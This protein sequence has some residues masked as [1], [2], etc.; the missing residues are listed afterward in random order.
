[1]PPSASLTSTPWIFKSFRVGA[2]EGYLAEKNPLTK[3]FD[4]LNN[5][6]VLFIMVSVVVLDIVFDIILLYKTNFLKKVFLRKG[7]LK[8]RI[9]KRRIFKR[10]MFKNKFSKR[11]ILK[12][13]VFKK[14][15]SETHS[16][17]AF[18]LLL[19]F[20]TQS[21]SLYTFINPG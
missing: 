8:R 18:F 11:K 7:V 10:R 1:M 4:L 3:S 15:I 5:Y 6:L 12:K 20:Y 9:F 16:F 14:Q 2:A 19:L 17:L 13:R 21:Q